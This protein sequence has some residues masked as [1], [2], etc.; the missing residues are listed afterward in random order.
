MAG[1]VFGLVAAEAAAAS[2]AYDEVR[3]IGRMVWWLESRPREGGRV[4]VMR[5]TEDGPPHE[6]TPP[7]TDVGSG[8]HGYGGGAYAVDADRVWYVD[9]A[10]GHIR[11]VDERN[12]AIVVVER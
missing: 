9:A 3:A 8:L 4:A 10:D 7:G 6:V 1:S 2:V 5:S 12:G 11:S